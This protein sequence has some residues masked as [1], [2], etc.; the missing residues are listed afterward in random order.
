VNILGFD[1]S[2]YDLEGKEI[3]YLR[4]YMQAFRMCREQGYDWFKL[5]DAED[6]YCGVSGC[7]GQKEILLSNLRKAMKALEE[8]DTQG[9]LADN[10][11]GTFEDEW[12]YRKPLLK[13]FMEKCIA[14]CEQNKKDS[15]LI[16]FY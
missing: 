4:A 1:I 11:D 14:W 6:Q 10:R 5:I 8:H 16:G 13:E 3:A 7:G 12:S 2:A 9:K 15:V